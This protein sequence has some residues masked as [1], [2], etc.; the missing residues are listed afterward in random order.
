MGTI[1]QKRL[2][3]AIVENAVAEKPLNKKQLLVNSGYSPLSASQSQTFIMDQKGLHEELDRLGFS[4]DAADIVVKTILKSSR[5]DEN[6][7]KAA[8]EIYKR[9]GAYAPDKKTSLN[10]NLDMDAKPQDVGKMELLRQEYEAKLRASI[11][12]EDEIV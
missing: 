2:A 3:K 8:Q 9:L 10:V 12:E 1:L 5:K 4:I 11:V 7:L 6:K